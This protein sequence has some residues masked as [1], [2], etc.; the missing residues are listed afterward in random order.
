MVYQ[1]QHIL[2]KER[3]DTKDANHWVGYIYASLSLYRAQADARTL[4]CLIK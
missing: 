3:V 4:C 2:T 1:T